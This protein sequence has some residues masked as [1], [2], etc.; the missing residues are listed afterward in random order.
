MRKRITVE[1]AEVEVARAELATLNADLA[2]SNEELEQFAYVASHDLQEPLRKVTSFVQLLQQR[3]GGQLDDRADTYI[4]FAVDGAKRMQTLIQDLLAFS[5]VGRTSTSIDDVDLGEAFASAVRSLGAGIEETGATVEAGPLPV[6][7]GNL[8]LLAVLWQN[9]LSNS[10][11]FR[12]DDP[13]VVSVEAMPAGDLWQCRLT[14]NGI[15]IDARFADKI[16]VI[17]QRLHSREAYE[18]TGIGLAMCKKIVEFHGGEIWLDPD[19]RPGTRISFTLPAIE[20]EA[21]S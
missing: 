16:F 15:G 6:V 1:L 21:P 17:F 8:G 11:K 13:P 9:L 10:L 2:R 19:D 20:G 7:R 3:Y 12:S 5:R 4:E 18:G 14:D